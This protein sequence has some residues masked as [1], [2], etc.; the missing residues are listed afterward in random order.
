[1]ATDKDK[2][3]VYFGLVFPLSSNNCGD[4]HLLVLGWDPHLII[5]KKKISIVQSG[6]GTIEI[7]NL[8][9]KKN[10]SKLWIQVNDQLQIYDLKTISIFYAIFIYLF[11]TKLNKFI[12]VYL[13][14]KC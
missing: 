12:V 11:I 14:Y 13:I 3:K 7:N 6:L 5:K 4:C 1:M 8:M 9:P 10:S 2:I